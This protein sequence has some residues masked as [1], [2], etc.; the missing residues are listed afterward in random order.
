MSIIT[1]IVAITIL[2]MVSFNGID[3]M[4]KMY[5]K[6]ELSYNTYF[7]TQIQLNASNIN[8]AQKTK[9]I[10]SQSQLEFIT[11]KQSFNKFYI[12]YKSQKQ[13]LTFKDLLI[14]KDRI[15]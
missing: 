5:A 3:L 4:N 2:V 12:S 13:V 11:L 14:S 9:R 15:K 8:K 10:L 1:N 6:D 7:L